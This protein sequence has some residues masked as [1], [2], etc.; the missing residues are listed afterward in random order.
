M[1][2]IVRSFAPTTIR[3]SGPGIGARQVKAIVSTGEV[4]RMG[5]IVVQSGIDLTAFRKSPT[6]LFQ[7]DPSQPIAKAI[8]IGLEGGSLAA[9][10]EFPAAGV[11]AKS[12][13]ILGLIKSGV[14]NSTSIGF[15]PKKSVPIDPSNPYSGRKFT[16]VELLEF[17]FV[18][19]AANAGA[20]ITG[21]SVSRTPRL[22][23]ARRRFA[24]MV[25]AK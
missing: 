20:L 22:D 19:I 23:D 17:S 6:I 8:S 7:H 12:D 4:D 18:S 2:E 1:T 3:F 25:R 5:D 9:L 10:V 16:K 15:V 14:V 21:R 13:E 24:E 11:S